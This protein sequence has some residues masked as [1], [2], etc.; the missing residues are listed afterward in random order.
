MSTS[1]SVEKKTKKTAKSASSK[2]V[3]M[4]KVSELKPVI[5]E[6]DVKVES[7]TET[8]VQSQVES[9]DSPSDIQETNSDFYSMMDKTIS[10][11]N[12]LNEISKKLDIIDE[13]Q[14]KSFIVEKKKMDKA[15]NTFEITYLESLASAFKVA[16]K[17]S[18][19]KSSKKVFDPANPG[20]EPAVKKPLECN[21]CLHTFL[22]KTD[23]TELISR[24]Q[25]YTAVT[26]FVKC[27]KKNNPEKI[28]ANLGNDKEFRVYGGLKTFLGSIS[29]IIV[30]NIKNI[31]A[32]IKVY[33]ASKPEEGTK[34][35]KELS[36]LHDEVE[37]LNKLK[38]IPDVMGY[39]NV[40]SYTNLCFTSDYIN[41]IKA[42]P[43]KSKSAKS[44]VKA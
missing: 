11:F 20:S 39:T 3:K 42:K 34:Q 38:T 21:S 43:S 17:A 24:N 35:M 31:E 32:E 19:K 30:N 29:K 15:I 13:K 8:Q 2:E 5:N 28:S 4:E 23:T 40:M 36:N 16:K 22:G 1:A 27:E 41:K 9:E 26:D 25:A 33:E 44:A 12:E 6:V 14:I 37:R 10:M 7:Q 18:S